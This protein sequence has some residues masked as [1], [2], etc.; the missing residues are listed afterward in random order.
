MP[1][2]VPEIRN[3]ARQTERRS[4]MKKDTLIVNAGRHPEAHHGVVNPPVYHA[5]TVTFPTVAAFDEAR[6]DRFNI[7]TYGRFGT[8]TTKAF[9]EAMAALEGG[10]RTVALSS[11]LAAAAVTLMAFVKSGDHVLMSDSAYGPARM[12]CDALLARFG[13]ETTYY[14]PLIGADIAGLMRP[15]TRLVYME[16]PGSLT[17]EMQ[18]VPAIAAAARAKG[19]LSAIDN[20]W[21]TAAYFKPLEAGV[22]LSIQAATKYIV[23]HSDAMLGAITMR[24]EHFETVKQTAN[25][26]GNCPG[27]EE[28]SLGLRG[29]R[30]LSVRLQRHRENAL[31]MALWFQARPEVERVLYPALPDDPGHAIWKRDFGGAS[32]LFTVV[33]HPCPPAA[34]AAMLD[35]LELFGLGASFGG[36]ESL[37]LPIS[38]ERFRTATEWP[39][40]GRTVRFHIGLEDPADLIAD[41]ELGFERLAAA[42]EKCEPRYCHERPNLHRRPIG[43]GPHRLRRRRAGARHRP[44]PRQRRGADAGLDEPRGGGRDPG[45]RRGPLLLALA[46]GAVA[47]GRAVGPH[48]GGQGRPHRLRRRH[49]AAAR[50]SEG[51]GLPHRTAQLLLQQRPRRHHRGHRRGRGRSGRDVRR[52]S[53]AN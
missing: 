5:S 13:V 41:L 7:V 20:T 32:G 51:R 40:P 39:A 34:I 24:D 21:A 19:A 28:C 50:R 25:L 47:Q 18:D 46:P 49:L 38:P 2:W 10:D 43:L 29:L 45:Q 3:F 48:P 37:V 31:V 15:E 36:Y 23:G 8:P 9:E 6:H 22:D 53:A 12:V 27:S 44:E 17:F 52:V 35:G 26:L 14:D 30:T 33:L 11:G 42:P 4:A 1:I 16:S